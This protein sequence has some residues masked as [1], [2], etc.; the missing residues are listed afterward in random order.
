[1]EQVKAMH[2]Y[3]HTHTQKHFFGTHRASLKFLYIV[4]VMLQTYNAGNPVSVP[5]GLWQ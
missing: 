4:K 1:M 3:A 2:V 5:L